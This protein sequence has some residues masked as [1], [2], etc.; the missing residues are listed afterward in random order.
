VRY[1]NPLQ[2]MINYSH[3]TD[4]KKNKTQQMSLIKK[5]FTNNVIIDDQSYMGG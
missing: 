4:L 2:G 1:E 5:Q 3:V